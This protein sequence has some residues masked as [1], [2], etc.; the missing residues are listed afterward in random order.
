MQ[1]S[2]ITTGNE[3]QGMPGLLHLH[4][5]TFGKRINQTIGT[6]ING[7]KPQAVGKLDLAHRTQCLMRRH[8]YEQPSLCECRDVSIQRPGNQDPN[9]CKLL[10]RIDGLLRASLADVK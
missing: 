8:P 9:S 4:G 10:G 1:G 3:F 7:S 5:S 6:P 2:C